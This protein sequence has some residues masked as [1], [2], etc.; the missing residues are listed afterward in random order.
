MND[1]IECKEMFLFA[2]RNVHDVGRSGS[3]C[4]MECGV[5]ARHTGVQLNF[6]LIGPRFEKDGWFFTC[7]VSVRIM[8]RLWSNAYQ[9]MI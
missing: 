3:V 5:A 7:F 1:S 2:Y 9:I 6:F 4:S 8:A